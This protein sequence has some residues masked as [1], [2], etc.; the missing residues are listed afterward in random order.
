LTAAEAAILDNKAVE[1]Y[2]SNIRNNRIACSEG[3]VF[4]I[5]YPFILPGSDLEE[6]NAK[7]QRQERLCPLNQIPRI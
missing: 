7:T 2:R 6:K 5:L 4:M 3:R 1:R